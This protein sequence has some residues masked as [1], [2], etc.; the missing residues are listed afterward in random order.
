MAEAFARIHGG[1]KVEADSAGNVVV[2]SSE[3]ITRKIQSPAARSDG[4]DSGAPFGSPAES[5]GERREPKKEV[6]SSTFS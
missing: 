1:T 5:F 6:R 3:L 2:E 4:N